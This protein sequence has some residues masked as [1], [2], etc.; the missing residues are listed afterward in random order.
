MNLSAI[1]EYF[2]G[3]DDAI[4]EIVGGFF[5]VN[6]AEETVIGVESFHRIAK[7]HDEFG[8]GVEVA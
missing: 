7:Y 2:D 1:V 8:R 4:V 3:I 5:F 6:R